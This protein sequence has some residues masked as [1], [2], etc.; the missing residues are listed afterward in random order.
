MAGQ[1][2][3]NTL[4]CTDSIGINESKRSERRP[5]IGRCSGAG[6]GVDPSRKK[7]GKV[8]GRNGES[9]L[10]LEEV[11]E[12]RSALVGDV[13]MSGTTWVTWNIESEAGRA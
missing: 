9:G 5:G 3:Q 13:V 6:G 2:R 7:A 8:G 11:S 12:A 1:L 4:D 10:S